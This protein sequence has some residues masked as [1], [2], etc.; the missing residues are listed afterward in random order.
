MLTHL[1]RDESFLD[2]PVGELSGG[3]S[4]LVALLRAVQLDPKV[5]LL[6]EPTASLDAEATAA[7][8]TLVADWQAE[9]AGARAV[10]WVSHDTGQAE[11]GLRTEQL[12]RG[13]LPGGRLRHDPA[14]VAAARN[15]L[16]S[17]TIRDRYR[18][19]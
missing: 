2:K 18:G 3:E 8:E 11:R 14:S 9:S 7:V 19:A 10:V 13:P 12:F 5:L 15:A 6:D 16:N 1:G 17:S 4:Q